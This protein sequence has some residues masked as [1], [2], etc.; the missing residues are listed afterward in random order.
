[1]KVYSVLYTST[2]TLF[3]DQ[4]ERKQSSMVVKAK[5][6]EEAKQKVMNELTSSGRHERIVIHSADVLKKVNNT[7]P[8]ITTIVVIGAIILMLVTF[9]N[10]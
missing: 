6:E 7:L 4:K 10:Q 2:E 5:N 3:D 9:L 1:M 8:L